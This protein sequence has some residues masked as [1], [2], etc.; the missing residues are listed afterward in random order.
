CLSRSHGFT[1]TR[2]RYGISACG[3]WQRFK[4]GEQ[5]R[6]GQQGA[7]FRQARDDL[8]THQ[9]KGVH[10]RATSRYTYRT[11]FSVS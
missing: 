8:G 7:A 6:V 5:L 3:G 9:R 10:D 1:G 4:I 11:I 2:H